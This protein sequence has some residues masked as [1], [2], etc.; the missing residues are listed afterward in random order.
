MVY[1]KLT[2]LKQ[3]TFMSS[4]GPGIQHGITR[5]LAHVSQAETTVSTGPESQLELRA[6]PPGR[7]GCW[8]GHVAGCTS[9]TETACA[10]DSWDPGS[11]GVPHRRVKPSPSWHGWMWCPPGQPGAL[12]VLSGENMG[13]FHQQSP[14]I[15]VSGHTV[16]DPC[17][18]ESAN[19]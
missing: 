8:Q 10:A 6:L 18:R 3:Y 17:P 11:C 15:S 12:G 14:G 16:G 1:H 9:S 7:S 5:S 2:S 4:W 13:L 19:H